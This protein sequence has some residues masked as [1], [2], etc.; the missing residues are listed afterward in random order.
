MKRFGEPVKFLVCVRVATVLSTYA[1]GTPWYL[2][3]LVAE[4]G[5]HP[6]SVLIWV[7]LIPVLTGGIVLNR[8][9][10][11]RVLDWWILRRMVTRVRPGLW[12]EWLDCTVGGGVTSGLRTTTRL[13][14]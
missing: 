11:H 6:Y 14:F 9:T 8:V 7:I 12:M 13:S 10:S 4:L 2:V 1:C 5:F 3:P